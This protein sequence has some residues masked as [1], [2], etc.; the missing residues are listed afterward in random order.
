M[1]TIVSTGPLVLLLTNDFSGR[2]TEKIIVGIFKRNCV[3]K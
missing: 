3:E 1:D 2:L